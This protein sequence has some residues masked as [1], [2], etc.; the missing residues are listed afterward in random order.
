MSYMLFNL[1]P[2]CSSTYSVPI[3][4]VHMWLGCRIQNYSAGRV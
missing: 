1:V 3:L 2:Q 4:D